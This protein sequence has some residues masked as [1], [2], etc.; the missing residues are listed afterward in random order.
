MRLMKWM[1]VFSA[2]SLCHLV[3]AK[4]YKWVDENGKVHFSDRPVDDK[5]EVVKME[6]GPSKVRVDEAKRRAKAM[7]N[8]N[9]NQNEKLWHETEEK[10]KQEAKLEAGK[11]ENQKACKE[12]RRLV[13]VYSGR[14]VIYVT[15]E[16]GKRK[17]LGLTD[18]QKNEKL[19]KLEKQIREECN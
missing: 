10:A 6:S 8:L 4:V 17:Y 12:A 13:L 2:L 3:D 18:E 19:A 16:D 14:G 5:S 11:E 1:F 7:K 9:E 15:D